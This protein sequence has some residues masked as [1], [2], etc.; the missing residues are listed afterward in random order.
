MMR[1][2]GGNPRNE[3]HGQAGAAG[4]SGAS[5]A[6]TPPQGVPP[7]QFLYSSSQTSSP[8]SLPAVGPGSSGMPSSLE[9]TVEL[10]IRARAG[11]PAALEALCLRCLKSLTRYAAGRLPP[12]V[13][14]ML[15]TQ[16]VVL[17]AV[18]RGMSRLGQFEVRHPGALVAYMRTT[19]RN[20]IIDYLRERIRQPRRVALD[21]QHPDKTRSPLERVLSDEQ[22]A[23]YDT[24]LTRLKPRDAA[25]VA[26]KIEEQ[27]SYDEIATEL[28]LPSGNAARVAARRAVL[29]LAHEMSRLSQVQ[30]EPDLAP[31]DAAAAKSESGAVSRGSD[32]ARSGS[33]KASGMKDLS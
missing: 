24:A 33:G 16:D 21:D 10:T 14:D 18:Q 19:L 7:I 2:G 22:I 26:L 6:L 3:T 25:L 28:G 9:S 32:A 5:G 29:R 15:D 30:H 8:A 23:L 31:R 1:S 4:A 12:A 20:L 17:E 13:R 11:D 27:L